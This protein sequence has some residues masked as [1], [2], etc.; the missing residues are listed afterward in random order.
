M[1]R[2]VDSFL[3]DLGELVKEQARA[4][5][6]AKDAAQG[7]DEFDYALGRLMAFH[8]IVS[9]M[10]QQANAF[11]IELSALGLDDISPERDLT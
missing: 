4:A 10:Q 8:E 6:D 3:W 5:K 7:S 11:D 9:M 1:T 2:R